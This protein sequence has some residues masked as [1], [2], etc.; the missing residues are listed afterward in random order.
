MMSTLRQ[1][2]GVFVDFKTR[3]E[4]ILRRPAPT[5]L[6]AFGPVITVCLAEVVCIYIFYRITKNKLHSS[7]D[8]GTVTL[9]AKSGKSGGTS[10]GAKSRGTAKQSQ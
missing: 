2:D 3:R 8:Q 7:G 6:S 10:S 1:A 9:E 4:A 5:F